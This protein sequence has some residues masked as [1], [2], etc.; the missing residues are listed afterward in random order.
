[1]NGSRNKQPTSRDA[2]RGPGETVDC[3]EHGPQPETFVCQ[4]VAHSLVSREPVGFH[5]PEDSDQQ[6]PDAWCSECDERH[7]RSG[8][9]W[10]GEAA[11]NLGAK[12]LCAGCYLEARKLALG[13]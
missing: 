1:M 7:Q 5:W 10:T 8:Y 3:G 11:D 6:F 2:P 4:H 9:E 13:E 12:V